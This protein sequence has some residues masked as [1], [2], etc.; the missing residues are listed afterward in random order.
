[1]ALYGNYPNKP[2]MRAVWDEYTG[3]SAIDILEY[4][5]LKQ[6]KHL[7]HCYKGKNYRSSKV[8][9]RLVAKQK[10][11]ELLRGKHETS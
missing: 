2:I 6:F 1:M 5:N 7:Q 4:K 11:L 10:T 9:N 8:L 3:L